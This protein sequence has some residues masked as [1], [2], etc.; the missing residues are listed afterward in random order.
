MVTH[1]YKPGG[2]TMPQLQQNQIVLNFSQE[3]TSLHL[4]HL[5]YINNKFSNLGRGDKPHSLDY[6]SH[7]NYKNRGPSPQI[8]L[9][10]PHPIP[11]SRVPY[12]N[13]AISPQNNICEHKLVQNLA[14]RAPVTRL[15]PYMPYINISQKGRERPILK[16]R[17]TIARRG[18]MP[19]PPQI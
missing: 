4:S 16:T 9:P 14:K 5:N 17:G 11:A 19:Q 2:S 10:R 15:H 6:L 13:Y 12:A 3:S 8:P 7:R 18:A 1:G